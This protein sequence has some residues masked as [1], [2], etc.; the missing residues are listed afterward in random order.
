MP[1]SREACSKTRSRPRQ[2]CAYSPTGPVG[3][4][5]AQ[6]PVAGGD[7]GVDVAGREDDDPRGRVAPGHVA[8]HDRVQG[9]GEV[10]PIRGAEL[11]PG[12]EED[13]REIGQ[14]LDLRRIEQVAGDR[15]DR[16]RL[17]GPR[18]RLGEEKRETAATRRGRPAASVA[19]A[20]EARQ[21][22][23]HLAARAEDDDVAVEARQERDVGG[24]RP[25]EQL[26]EL[27][28][29]TDDR[30]QV[31]GDRGRRSAHGRGSVMGPG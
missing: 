4:V 27:L 25:R 6:P 21:R 10:G 24:A 13:V 18:R 8:G 14:P 9:P 2:D 19:R 16:R 5:S 29:V 31:A 20:D 15:L 22:R 30:G 23:A 3:S 12:E 26:F 7:Q 11:H 28:L 1:R 17:R